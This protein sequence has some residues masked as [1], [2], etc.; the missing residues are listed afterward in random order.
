[1]FMG[2]TSITQGISR[3]FRLGGAFLLAVLPLKVSAEDSFAL[4]ESP[5]NSPVFRVSA[6]LDV[7]GKLKTTTDKEKTLDLD[8]RVDAVFD[9][10]E[11]R[12]PGAGRDALTLRSVR[13]YIQAQA[14]IN[15]NRNRSFS[16]LPKANAVIV[17]HGNRAGLEFYQT[18]ASMTKSELD[19]L[20]VPGDGLA[21][22]GL[23]PQTKV[24]VGQKWTAESW[25]VQMLTGTEALLK[26][27]VSCELES[28]KDQLARVKFDGSVEG[29]IQ[30]ATTAIN[31]NGHYVFDLKKNYLR[32]V[33]L[34]Q[35]EKRGVGAVSPGMDVVASM[36]LSRSPDITEGQLKA[37]ALAEIPLE[38]TPE[39]LELDLKL[40][41]NATISH[42]RDWH[43]FQRTPKQTVLRLIQDG[44]LIA[45]CNLSP[46]S[47]P[48]TSDRLSESEFREL[49]NKG[50][51]E[52]LKSIET[53][54]TLSDAPD[55]TIDRITAEG[56]S[57]KINMT[58]HYYQAI[59]KSGRMLFFVAVE[60][61]LKEKLGEADL[62]LVQSLTMENPDLI[63][64]SGE[65]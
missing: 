4:Q 2:T 48:K 32:S 63:P 29:A 39:Q 47:E 38:P 31:L 44:N 53:Y 28:V 51:G 7:R 34:R 14:N 49:V 15:V 24:E 17:A 58:W 21:V 62:K 33:E 3:V 65:K 26:S 6:E 57:Q 64:A 1:M 13:E 35:T 46:L 20:Q 30:G 23:L 5:T 54:E 18:D 37:D 55:L 60:T 36:K 8:L 43:I 41:W 52:S 12:L 19:L 27:S 42:S 11:R 59:T 45:Q 9:Y 50:L 25:A 56:E 22:L 16:T 61:D 10:R 40:P